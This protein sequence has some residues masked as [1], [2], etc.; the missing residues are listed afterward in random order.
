MDK[1]RTKIKEDDI[2]KNVEKALI[3]AGIKAKKEA[4][5]LG[6]P[7]YIF[8]NGKIVNLLAKKKK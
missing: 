3:R 8:R 2:F 5:R 4:Q 1:S 7:F 6:A